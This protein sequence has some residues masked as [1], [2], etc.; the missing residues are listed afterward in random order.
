MTESDDYKRGFYDGYQAAKKAQ[1]YPKIYPTQPLPAKTEDIMWPDRLPT[2][3]P[4]PPTMPVVYQACG[5]C[6]IGGDINKAMGYVCNNPQCPTRVTC[7]TTG[8]ST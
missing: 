4:F 6:G 1:D 7:T 2:T 5:V 3:S 8:T